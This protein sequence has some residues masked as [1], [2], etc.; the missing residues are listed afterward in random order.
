MKYS[1]DHPDIPLTTILILLY[2]LIHPLKNNK[3]LII[4]VPVGLQ[5]M[6]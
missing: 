5:A 3:S 4:S 6:A 1:R 2:P